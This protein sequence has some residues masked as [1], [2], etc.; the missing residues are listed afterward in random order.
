MTT[1]YYKAYLPEIGVDVTTHFVGQTSYTKALSQ[2]WIFD[3]LRLYVTLMRKT[4]EIHRKSFSDDT[5]EA[6][7][8]TG[9]SRQLKPCQYGLKRDL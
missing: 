2:T 4:V 9:L 3:S 7:Y 8:S 6:K 1:L 5:G